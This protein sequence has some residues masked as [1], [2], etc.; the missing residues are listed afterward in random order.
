M[1]SHYCMSHTSWITGR[2]RTP[3]STP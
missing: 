2:L 1:L 3:R